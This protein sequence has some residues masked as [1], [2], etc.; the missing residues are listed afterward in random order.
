MSKEEWILSYE[1]ALDN[2]AEEHDIDNEDAQIILD[3][4]LDD[5]THYLDGYLAYD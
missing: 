3:K 4:I 1:R 2:I 5:D